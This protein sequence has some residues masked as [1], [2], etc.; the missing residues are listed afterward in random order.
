MLNTKT[1]TVAT[2]ALL[3]LL[4]SGGIF[5]AL[6]YQV[7]EKKL[8]FHSGLRERA[9]SL[10]TNRQ[11]D[12]LVGLVDE[13]AEERA[14]LSAYVLAEDSVINFLTL[15]EDLAA[16]HGV[17]IE[18]RSL[19]VDPIGGDDLFEQLTLT[20]EVRGTYTQVSHMLRIFEALP[21]Q[22]DI[23][24][25]TLGRIGNGNEWTGTFSVRVTKFKA[26]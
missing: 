13:T 18:T 21:Y 6:L 2:I 4:L 10:A 8:M 22:A 9:E 5:G 15:I 25:V 26:L 19:S 14:R 24:R 11:L 23:H 7:H 12:A 1:K 17:D 3:T 16:E 20:I